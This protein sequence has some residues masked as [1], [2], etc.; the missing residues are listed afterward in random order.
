MCRDFHTSP[1]KKIASAPLLPASAEISV[2]TNQG[3]KFIR[4]RLSKSELGTEV[5][6]FVGQHLQVAGG[7]AS[8][9]HLRKVRRVLSRERQLL[10]ELPE[11]AVLV[12]FNQRVRDPTKRLLD[13]LLIGQH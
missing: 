9:S 11:F 5:V 10:L 6:G 3:Y 8:I 1:H 2:N 4:L 13:R 7:S 12:I